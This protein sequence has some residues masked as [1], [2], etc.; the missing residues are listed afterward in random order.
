MYYI[1][2]G[3]RN[4]SKYARSDEEGIKTVDKDAKGV[5]NSS[6]Q[7][8]DCTKAEEQDDTKVQKNRELVP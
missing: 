8:R 3:A 1:R 2:V 6:E 5:K 4:S 7:V